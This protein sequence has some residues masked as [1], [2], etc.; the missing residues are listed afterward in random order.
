MAG[1]PAKTKNSPSLKWWAV[2]MC[3]GGG[4]IFNIQMGYLN[5]FFNLYFLFVHSLE[6]NQGLELNAFL[7]I[8]GACAPF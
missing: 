6:V 7:G 3:V 1:I 2:C 8:L 5:L 4:N